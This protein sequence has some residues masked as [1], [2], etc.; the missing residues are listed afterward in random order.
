M[1]KFTSQEVSA[2]QGG[3]NAS[4]K[5]IYFKEWDAQRQSFPDSR[6]TSGLHQACL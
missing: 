4:A 1:A 5:E 3:E 2:L 6:E